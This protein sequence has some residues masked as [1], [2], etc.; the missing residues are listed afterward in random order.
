[1]PDIR[2]V[3]ILDAAL[4]RASE[5]LRVVEDYLRM[6]LDDGHLAQLAKQLRHDLAT[7]AAVLPTQLRHASRDTLGDVGTRNAT[8]TEQVRRSPVD[9]ATASFSRTAQAL[10]SIEEYGKL[11]DGE[12]AA[13]CESIRYRLYTLE[14]AWSTTHAS[15]ARLAGAQLYVLVDGCDSE[16]EFAQL[17]ESLVEAG[18]D[19][20]QL[21]DKQLDDRALLGRAERLMA[22]TRG[23]PTLAI[24]NDRADIAAAAH[25]HGVHLG[26]NELP[27]AAARRILGPEILIGVSTHCILQARQAV[28]DG[29]T[30]LGAGP[31]FASGTKQFDHFPGLDYL[32]Q[33]A[34]EVSLPTFA[35]GG[36]TVDNLP[37]VL[38]TGI[39]RVAVAGAVTGAENPAAAVANLRAKLD[40]MAAVGSA[41]RI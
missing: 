38:A 10:R 33:V 40:E 25:A 12:L 36:I 5:G 8:A 32:R 11:V 30:Y 14:K 39:T 3:R 41:G 34:A 9:V 26:Q 18:A 20:L 15:L 31:T 27:V 35:I 4:N 6:V 21:R 28:L 37:D 13:R 19:V 22:A 16:G 29:A 24:V 23:T 1:M 17:A 7:A 2:A